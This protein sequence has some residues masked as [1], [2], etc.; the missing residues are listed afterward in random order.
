[1]PLI[2]NHL[3]TRLADLL[4]E[5]EVYN[6]HLYRPN[7]YQHKWWARRCGS[8]FRL[9]LKH[10][11]EG[12]ANY[13]ESGG[14]E[15]V[16]ILDPMMGGGTTLH[17]AIRLGASVIGCDIEPIPVL[18]ARAALT[19]IPLARLEDAFRQLYAAVY[20]DVGHLFITHCRY[21]RAPSHFSDDNGS[22]A[23][24]VK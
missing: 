10:L 17:E 3:N 21:S 18:N 24:C 4:A 23:I 19:Y 1:M 16:I 8:T 15:G 2:D 12:D 13:Y 11:V 7:S 5:R 20:A 22:P 14:L 6:K 9:I